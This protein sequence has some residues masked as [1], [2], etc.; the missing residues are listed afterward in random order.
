M[1]HNDE[2]ATNY[3][4]TRSDTKQIFFFASLRVTSWLVSFLFLLACHHA[5]A[6]GR[7]DSP[8]RVARP[9]TMSE[10][11]S[12]RTGGVSVAEVS[13]YVYGNYQGD[14]PSP[15]HADLNP[16]K[17]FVIFW[18]DFDY[19]FVF[20]H[21]ASYCPWFELSSGAAVSYQFFEGNQGWA[22]LFNDPGRQER[23]S[24]VEIIETGP[25]RVW[26]RWHYTGVNMQ[27]G[28]AA[29]RGVEDF[30]AFPN[31]LVLRRQRYYSLM[32]GDERGY[33]R[34][35]IELIVMS[36]AGKLWFDVLA[37]EAATGEGRAFVGVDAF[38][39]ARVDIFWK[40]APKPRQ[41]W[42]GSS[43]RTGSPWKEIDDAR[44][45]AAVVPLKDGSPFFVIGDASGFA[46]ETTRLK[47]HSDKTT[48]GWGWRTLTW[49]HWPVG[50]LNSQAHDTDDE[51]YKHYPSHFAPFGLDLWSVPN[52]QTERRDYF[53]LLG[54]G[55]GDVEAIRGLARNWLENGPRAA[56]A[57]ARV[58]SLRP[59][60][61]AM[62]GGRS[63]R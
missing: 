38:S 36:P 25:R 48:G 18:K 10:L 59:L 6:Q 61:D 8:F 3:E 40:S 2:P 24:F 26:V 56:T 1:R 52:E 13:D 37:Q 20:S 53:S 60:K 19:R 5:T 34:E 22:E 51:S 31:G 55:G 47:E 41:P 14:F 39:K 17:A 9:V 11:K 16:K 7:D 46:H 30:W 42:A 4:V 27:S 57:P 12:I 28:A 32:P 23:N 50:W 43:R 45:V 49:D 58:N 33:A 54:V 62:R 35:P 44:G 21:E 29:F 15:P 63:R